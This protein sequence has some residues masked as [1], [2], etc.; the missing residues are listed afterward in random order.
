M[1]GNEYEII[2]QPHGRHGNTALLP[3]YYNNDD[4]DNDDNDDDRI[5]YTEHVVRVVVSED[6]VVFFPHQIL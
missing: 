1:Q 6:L 5:L 4:N 2:L 3:L